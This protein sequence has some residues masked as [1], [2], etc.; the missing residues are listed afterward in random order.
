MASP[1]PFSGGNILNASDLNEIG[2]ME[3]FTPTF[4]NVTLGASGVVQGR[5]A[6]IQNLV[7]YKASFELGG[8]GSITGHV[9]MDLPVGT[10]DTN[11]TYQIASQAWMRPAG[12]TIYHAMTYQASSEVF[13][14]VYDTSG[15]RASI[16][17]VD[18]TDPATWTSA[19]S[20]YVSGW[21]LTT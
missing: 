6:Q 13:F 15:T 19:G 7:F 21:Y 11:T 4:N 8:T 17:N 18:A 5:Y 2:D 9:S 10:G 20:G 16:Q 14:Y 1:F 12:F 3:T